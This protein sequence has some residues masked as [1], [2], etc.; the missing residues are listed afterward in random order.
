MFVK[1][2]MGPALAAGNTVLVKPS[3]IAPLSTLRVAELMAEGR[4]KRPAAKKRP[5]PQMVPST[6]INQRLL[7]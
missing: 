6:R 2:N 1:W 5:K 7:A 3:E 4:Y